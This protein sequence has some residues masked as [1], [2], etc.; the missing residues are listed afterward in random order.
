MPRSSNLRVVSG[1]KLVSKFLQETF[2]RSRQHL[3]FVENAL[4]RQVDVGF[5]NLS[6]HSR[7]R[8]L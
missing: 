4:A 1:R 6:L 5:K 2:R 3:F 8:L 7:E